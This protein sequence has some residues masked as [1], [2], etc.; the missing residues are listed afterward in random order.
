MTEA[1]KFADE[2]TQALKARQLDRGASGR[3]PRFTIHT[4]SLPDKHIHLTIRP[5][6][7]G[8]YG[9]LDDGKSPHDRFRVFEW[10]DKI[11]DRVT[12][13]VDGFV[14]MLYALELSN[15]MHAFLERSGC[16]GAAAVRKEIEKEM[17][18]EKAAFAREEDPDQVRALYA[19]A[20]VRHARLSGDIACPFCGDANLSAAG[21]RIECVCGAVWLGYEA[22]WIR[23]K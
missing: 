6:H 20:I 18:A 8:G 11:L 16:R 1:Q 7:P 21:D 5:V 2:L 13:W 3:V 22:R 10:D 14:T 12:D 15:V 17:R 23:P 19:A 9:L 4:K